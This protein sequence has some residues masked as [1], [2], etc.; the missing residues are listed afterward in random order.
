MSQVESLAR[1]ARTAA[2]V[3]ANSSEEQ[4][5]AALT[6][7]AAALRDGVEEILR[8]NQADLE[9]A[10]GL[11]DALRDRLALSPARIEAMAA[12]VEAV[13]DLP[14][15]VGKELSS[16]TRPNGL[17]IR[18]VRVPLG[19]VG[20]IYEARPNVTVDAGVL[21]LKS[22]NACV[23]RGGK[24]AVRS[25]AALSRLM[26]QALSRTGLPEDCICFVTDTDRSSAREMMQLHGL[27]DVLIPRGGAGLI[28]TVVEQA[29][30]PV[31][32][33]GVGNCHIYVDA[34]ADLDMAVEILYNAKCSRPSVCNAAESLLVHQSVAA[35]FLPRA[36]A[37]LQEKHVV[38]YGCPRTCALIPQALPAGE[39]EYARE[40]LDYA[41]SCRVVDSLEEALDH[42]AR[43]STNHSEAIVTDDAAA[44]ETFLQRVDA[45][46]VYWNAST[47]FTDG[48]EFG[49]GAEIGISTQKMHVR[50][51]MG[52]EALTSS[53]YLISGTGQIR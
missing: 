46:A 10:S 45:A 30:I 31:I 35:A 51:P 24:E 17:L 22:G 5:N 8:E 38:F 39:E 49:L 50:G 3:L 28:R 18:Q 34:A 40:F 33:T 11:S 21:C 9:A 7:I 32:E 27:I 36:Y 20:M 14:D 6:A 19:V 53:K 43:Y 1:Q 4:K 41:L 23:L 12:G 16:V 37:R 25:G 47:R 44:A 48:G 29:R 2:R 15:P 52:L 13:R 42:I 26:R